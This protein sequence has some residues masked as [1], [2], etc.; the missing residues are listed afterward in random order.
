MKDVAWVCRV[1]C[2]IVNQHTPLSPL[3]AGFAC[4]RRYK[5]IPLFFCQSQVCEGALSAAHPSSEQ[6]TLIL[7]VCAVPL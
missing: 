6:L 2:S 7:L 1:S 5:V 3:S 4:A